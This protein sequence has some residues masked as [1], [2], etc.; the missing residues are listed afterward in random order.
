MLSG[1]RVV[2]RP[3]TP[4]DYPALYAWRID[5]ASWANASSR[6]LWPLT[7]PDFRDWY[8]RVVRDD[9]CAEFA[10]EVD[11]TLAG[12]CGL[13]DVD[14]L[15]RTAQLGI[16][17]GPEHRG[18]GYGRDAVRVLVDYAFTHR[19]LRR[20]WLECLAVNTAALRA[21]VAAGFTEEGRLREHAWVEGTYV[22]AVRMAVLR[23]DPPGEQR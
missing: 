9:T 18:K 14:A 19:N 20:V 13:F 4:D 21:Y 11:G 3:T 12:R 16:A 2:L 23:D 22:D 7:Y 15:A 1:E 17:L 10:V 6:P 5:V 8:E